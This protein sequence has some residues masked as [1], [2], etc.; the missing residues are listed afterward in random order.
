MAQTF[1]ESGIPIEARKRRERHEALWGRH[2]DAKRLIRE[3]VA[4]DRPGLGVALAECRRSYSVEKSVSAADKFAL[5]SRSSCR[6]LPWCI[7]CTRAAVW[8]RVRRVEDAFSRC[9]PPGEKVRCCHMVFSAPLTPGGEGWGATAMRKLGGFFSAVY[10]T[11]KD[12]FGAGVGGWASY[13]DFGEVPFT[14]KAPHVDLTLNGWMVEGGVL[15]RVRELD[16]A[17]GE[18]Q[19]LNEAY[20]RRATKF[21]FDLADRPGNSWVGPVREGLSAVRGTV[22]YQVRELVDLR[23]VRYPEGS[24]RV[25]WEN[26]KDGSVD[27]LPDDRFCGWYREYEDRV[28]P[29]ESNHVHRGFGFMAGR[30]RGRVARLGFRDEAVAHEAGCACR[31]CDD[32]ERVV[33]AGSLYPGL[34][35]GPGWAVPDGGRGAELS[36]RAP[37]VRSR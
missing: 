25:G 7:P 1:P 14:K 27:W 21:G 34:D 15:V 5:R 28:R 35:A 20:A 4:A 8:G 23:K 13:Q 37:A 32:W 3:W 12:V 16:I 6:W 24:R 33:E 19:R 9:T 29:H 18:K 10:D 2:P 22:A 17:R 31:E 11:V 26:Y 30:L 36:G